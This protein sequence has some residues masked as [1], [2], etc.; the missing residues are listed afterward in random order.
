[1]NPSEAAEILKALQSPERPT[2]GALATIVSTSG[3][4]YRR[5]GARLVVGDRGRTIGNISGGCLEHEVEQEAHGVVTEG[6]ARL[7]SYD[8]AAE[9]EAVWGWGMGCNGTIEVFIEPVTEGHAL[10]AA[11]RLSREGRAVAMATLLQPRPGF[12][13]GAHLLVSAHGEREGSLG[14]GPADRAVETELQRALAGRTPTTLDLELDCG[15]VFVEVI[16]PGPRL[17]VCGAGDDAAAVAQLSSGLGWRVVVTDDRHSLL[18][19][20]RFPSTTELVH[21]VPETVGS[22]VVDSGSF[23]ILMTHNYSRDLAYLRGLAAS[24]ATYI[25][26]LG[27]RARLARLMHDLGDEGGKLE[28]KVHGPAGLDIGAE[29]PEEIAVSVVAEIMAV[30]SSHEGGFLKNRASVH[31]NQSRK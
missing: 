3:S 27:P 24:P 10:T 23:V 28:T 5:P 2:P 20:D 19:R 11:L 14:S 7:R 25:G 12:E 21:S 6:R 17:V 13:R 29:G 31:H 1:M 30:R 16:M 15:R 9:D 4:T 18:E 8:L 26:L 22:E